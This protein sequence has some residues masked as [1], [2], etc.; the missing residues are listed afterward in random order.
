M[1]KYLADY[2]LDLLPEGW[3]ECTVMKFN[4]VNANSGKTAVAFTLQGDEDKTI[5]L[6]FWLTDKALWRFAKFA[7]ACGLNKEQRQKLDAENEQFY[8][9]F[10]GRR[11]RALV[12]LS[13]ANE[14]GKRFLECDEFEASAEEQPPVIMPDDIPF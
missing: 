10:V 3:H 11:I 7:A 4:A 8:P 9:V 13:E 12:E 6:T 2:E 5:G 14:K 1:A